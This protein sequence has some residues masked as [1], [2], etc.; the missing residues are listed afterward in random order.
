MGLSGNIEDLPLSDIIQIVHLSKK[1][2]TLS[3]QNQTDEGAIIFREGLIIQATS[4]K[5]KKRLIQNLLDNKV[6]NLQQLKEAKELKDG[7]YTHLNISAILIE[8]GFINLSI[9]EKFVRDSILKV[10]SQLLEWQTGNFTFDLGNIGLSPLHEKIVDN[11]LLEYGLT[12][13]EL[14]T[15][16]V[17]NAEMEKS[18]LATIENKKSTSQKTPPDVK[19]SAKLIQNKKEQKGTKEDKQKDEMNLN[20]KKFPLPSLS[21]QS[22]SAQTKN[23][24]VIIDDEQ[25]FLNII[26]NKLTELD[27]EVFSFVS[28]DPAKLKLVELLE[29]NFNPILVTDIVLPSS[30][31]SSNLGGLEFLEEISKSYPSIPVILISDLQDSALR[32]QAYEKGARNFLKKPNRA[33]ISVKKLPEIINY[34]GSELAL[35]IKN[36]INERIRLQGIVSSISTVKKIY[37]LQNK[38]KLDSKAKSPENEFKKMK[39]IFYELQN[40]K[41]TSE[42]I[43]LVLRLASEHLE[44]GILFLHTSKSLNGIGGFGYAVSGEP[45]VSRITSFKLPIATSSVFTQIVENRQ[46]FSGIP[47]Q[48]QTQEILYQEIGKPLNGKIVA[49]PLM[50]EGRIIAIFYGDNGTRMK[51]FENLIGLELFINQAGIA[52][53]NALLQ[54]KLK[55]KLF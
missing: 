54:K 10:I 18:N 12:P 3:L 45:I 5:T 41:E 8:Q 44:R 42:V 22:D 49:I 43:L 2:G 28:V 37:P 29:N 26:S 53:E 4:S 21:M 25:V 36:I 14:F 35:C 24:I 7:K 20:D 40:P 51:E 46:M 50:S 1:T 6:I 39:Q 48:S 34:F 32:Y 9:L 16:A 11:V 47:I 38:K 27:Y 19:D 17:I 23:Y 52:L 30:K 55:G 31:S 15:K 33:D 13:Q